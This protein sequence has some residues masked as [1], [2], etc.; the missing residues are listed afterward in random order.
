MSFL[1]ES[2]QS[3]SCLEFYYLIIW[4]EPVPMGTPCAEVTKGI[5]RDFLVA[6]CGSKK[7]IME[8]KPSFFVRIE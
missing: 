6:G 8:P 3:F 2:D 7:Q 5:G 1:W 4:W